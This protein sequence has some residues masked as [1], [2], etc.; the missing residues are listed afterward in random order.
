[1]KTKEELNNIAF[2]KA[3]EYE[4]KYWA[5]RENPNKAMISAFVAGYTAAIL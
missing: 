2:N 3:V 5:D 4:K 1:M